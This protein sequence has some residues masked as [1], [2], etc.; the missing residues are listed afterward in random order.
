MVPHGEQL[1]LNLEQRIPAASDKHFGGHVDYTA[2]RT[3]TSDAG[4]LLQ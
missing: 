2:I 4:N 3:S 1:V